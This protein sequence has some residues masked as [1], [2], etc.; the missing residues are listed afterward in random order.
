M[1]KEILQE[2]KK[3]NETLN[4]ILAATIENGNARAQNFGQLDRN[5]NNRIDE[6]IKAVEGKR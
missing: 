3:M 5:I 4:K 2:L 6:L 1:D